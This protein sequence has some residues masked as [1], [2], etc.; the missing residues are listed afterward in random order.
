MGGLFSPPAISG[1]KL[2]TKQMSPNSDG[3]LD[4]VQ[5]SYA[6]SEPSQW[7]VQVLNAGGQSVRRYS[8]AGASVKVI[9]NGKNEAGATVADGVYTLKMSATSA[10]GAMST[11]TAQT[12]GRHGGAATPGCAS[13]AGHV[14]P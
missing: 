1:L 5:V 14:Q 2:S 6:I 4:S 8:G 7:T 12:D 10:F 13:G 9:W 3:V 11:K